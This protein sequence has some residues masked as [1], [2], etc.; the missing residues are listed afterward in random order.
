MK[1]RAEGR[2]VCNP[3]S[4]NG[5]RSKILI[6]SKLASKPVAPRPRVPAT[7]TPK[8]KYRAEVRNFTETY[9]SATKK[10]TRMTVPSRVSRVSLGGGGGTRG[11]GSIV[12]MTI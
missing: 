1:F 10:A 7:K 11:E 2:P 12:G 4:V 9:T 3:I 5:R 6:V 8:T